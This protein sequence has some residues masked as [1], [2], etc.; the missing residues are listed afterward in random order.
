MSRAPRLEGFTVLT[1]AMGAVLLGLGTWQL[2]RLNWKEALIAERTARL[3][4][5]PLPLRPG[6]TTPET[7]GALDFRRVELSG[8]Y[9]HQDELLLVAPSITGQAGYHVVTPLERP[10]GDLVLV[11][12][13]W[14]PYRLRA[15]ETRAGGQVEGPVTITGIA[16][17]AGRQGLFV[18]D[19]EPG[20][21][22]WYWRDLEGMAAHLGR[23]VAPILVEAGPEPNPGG[24]PVG[25]QTLLKLPNDHLGYALTWYALA[26]ALAA[27]YL[28]RRRKATRADGGGR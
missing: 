21:G 22:L 20:N 24:Y 25:G 16:R 19:N 6:A 1:L 27:V 11:S 23:E 13:G 8:R 18:P 2:E 14:I 7:P 26:A 3:A 17:T 9:R 12:R 10:G 4:A 5:P 28:V 15:P